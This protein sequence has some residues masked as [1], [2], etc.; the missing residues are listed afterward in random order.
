MPKSSLKKGSD[1][2]IVD[3][4]TSIVSTIPSDILVYFLLSECDG[5]LFRFRLPEAGV[6][7]HVGCRLQ[8]SV[9]RSI[10]LIQNKSSFVYTSLLHE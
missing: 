5:Y 4:N 6:L 9:F 8:Y 2:N 1:I 7:V 3:Q 10:K